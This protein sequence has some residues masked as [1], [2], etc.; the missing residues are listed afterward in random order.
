MAIGLVAEQS[1]A[2][3]AGDTGKVVW[4]TAAVLTEL[5]PLALDSKLI[6]IGVGTAVMPVVKLV[7]APVKVMAPLNEFV[8]TGGEPAVTM[9]VVGTLLPLTKTW[10]RLPVP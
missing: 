10:F 6:Q 8:N 9:M 1:V 2:A 7:V 4:S 5:Q 3:V